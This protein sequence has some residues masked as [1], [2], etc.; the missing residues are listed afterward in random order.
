MDAEAAASGFKGM[1][2][3]GLLEGACNL[4]GP[5]R[6]LDK[7]RDELTNVHHAWLNQEKGVQE[8]QVGAE[9]RALVDLGPISKWRGAGDGADAALN[10]TLYLMTV[11]M[12][13][14][15]VAC[16]A[17]PH[18]GA[19]DAVLRTLVGAIQGLCRRH[20]R[21][22]AA[23]ASLA[24]IPVASAPGGR[25]GREDIPPR[26]QLRANAMPAL[27]SDLYYCLAEYCASRGLAVDPISLRLSERL[28]EDDRAAVIEALTKDNP[29]YDGL[30]EQRREAPA[31]GT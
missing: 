20:G 19:E 10:H 8:A 31:G 2:L 9:D 30:D 22:A 24:G 28:T 11:V 27:I 1:S 29:L 5:L 25:A 15:T 7:M 13:V 14:G 4:H 3:P 12:S 6:D 23:E 17:E 18:T 21:A 26:R 16:E